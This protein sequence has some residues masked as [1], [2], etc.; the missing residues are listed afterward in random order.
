MMVWYILY[1]C[2]I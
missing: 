2:S 1:R